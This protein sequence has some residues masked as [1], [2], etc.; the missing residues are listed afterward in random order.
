M[1]CLIFLKYKFMNTLN[2]P[3]RHSGLHGFHYF[4]L[5]GTGNAYRF[6][7]QFKF[8]FRFYTPQVVHDIDQILGVK[9]VRRRF[10]IDYGAS[11][12]WITHFCLELAD[13]VIQVAGV[14]GIVADIIMEIKEQYFIKSGKIQIVFIE[15]EVGENL[16]QAK[17]FPYALRS[18]SSAV[19]HLPEST[20]RL[21]KYYLVVFRSIRRDLFFLEYQE[22]G[23]G[24]TISREI[25]EVRILVIQV[26][27]VVRPVS[28]R[29]GKEYSYRVLRKL[30]AECRPPLPVKF[31]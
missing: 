24:L 29:V 20:S 16:F 6:P 9:I 30:S 13:Q 19:P 3:L 5:S 28:D 15:V 11:R 2:F 27:D 31:T 14:V 17:F 10:R 12:R 7:D 23:V 26:V 8:F 18:Q 25:V 21:D 4:D 1:L 22:D